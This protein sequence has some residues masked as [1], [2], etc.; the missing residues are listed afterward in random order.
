MLKRT[1]VL[2]LL[3]FT[4]LPNVI[5]QIKNETIWDVKKLK[6]APKFQIESDT[7]GVKALLFNSVDYKGKATQ[8]FAYYS[9]PNLIRKSTTTK[10]KFPGVVLIHGG[11]GKAYHEWVK[12]WA[13]AGYAAIALDLTGKGKDGK[14][15]A[16]G[17]PLMGDSTIFFAIHENLKNTW[18]YHSVASAILAHSLI[19]SFPEIDVNSTVVTGI[20]W[21]GYLT[22]ILIGIDDRFKAAVPVY[23]CGYYNDIS[24]FRQKLNLLSES[25][26]KT[27]LTNLDPSVYLSKTNMKT[28]FL[29][30]NK[31]KFFTVVPYA[32]TYNLVNRQNRYITIIPDMK[33]GHNYGWDPVEI[34]Y[35]FDD[36]LSNKNSFPKVLSINFKDTLLTASYHSPT[37]IVSATLYYSND[38][39]TPSENRIW[40]VKKVAINSD[41]AS[42]NA[43]IAQNEFKFAF[44]HLKNSSGISFSS[45][46]IFQERLEKN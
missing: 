5:A 43:N 45:E 12:K 30:G 10:S 46:Y 33:H 20:S 34:K 35:F 26:K 6:T 37:P 32:K 13:L 40:Q 27:W 41:K 16:N 7:A 8:V 36:V 31:D 21:G 29:N 11:G 1:I 15:L 28:L 23:G 14:K 39:A 9:N 24:V 25:D 3:V 17:G 42:I 44:F 22:D 4:A 38:A 18:T 2:L 19:R